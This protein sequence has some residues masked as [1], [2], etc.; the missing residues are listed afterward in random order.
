M[1]ARNWHRHFAT[2]RFPALRESRLLYRELKIFDPE[3]NVSPDSNENN[4]NLDETDQIISNQ[5]LSLA[6]IIENRESILERSKQAQERIQTITNR[7]QGSSSPEIRALMHS[8]QSWHKGIDTKLSLVNKL[9]S[10]Q[11]EWERGRLEPQGYVDALQEFLTMTDAKKTIT[12]PEKYAIDASTWLQLSMEER[13]RIRLELENYFTNQDVGDPGSGAKKLIEEVE[14]QIDESDMEL[15]NLI[16]EI[17]EQQEE[18]SGDNRGLIETL[19]TA[20][21]KIRLYSVMDF[22]RAGQKYVEGVKN[23]WSKRAERVSA[24][25]ASQVG[26]IMKFLPLG[27]EIDA[28][29]SAARES[30]NDEEKEQQKKLMEQNSVPFTQAIQSLRTMQHNPNKFNG[31]LEYLADHGWLY[32]FDPTSRKAFG[33]EI[34]R[35]N[36]WNDASLQEYLIRIWSTDSDSGQESQKKRM[37][38]L[39]GTADSI[40][41]IAEQLEEELDR[42]NYWAVYA[43]LETAMNKGKIG[44]SG[45]WI[46]TIFLNHLRKHPEARKYIPIDIHDQL[47]NLGI[48]HPAW[49]PTFLKVDRK[50]LESWQKSDDPDAFQYSGTLSKAI[51]MIEEEITQKFGNEAAIKQ[52]FGNDM[53]LNRLVARVLSAQVVSHN[54]VSVTLFSSRYSRY[55]EALLEADTTIEV[56]K[57][58]DDFYGNISDAHLIGVGGIRSIFQMTTQGG[59]QHLTKANSY[60]ANIFKLDEKLKESRNMDALR[61]YRKEMQDKLNKYFEEDVSRHSATTQ[62]WL[63]RSLPKYGNLLEQFKSHGMLSQ[64][65]YDTVF[66]EELAKKEKAS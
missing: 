42:Y 47:G 43:A 65:V 3:E 34:P 25:L 45:T 24:G 63:T 29:L 61:N 53:T 6:E 55:R 26:S 49:T 12:L 23:A 31:V 4:S 59:F 54:G 16:N 18:S 39:I 64:K 30:K 38:N 19:Q 32:D 33:I 35:P 51:V 21:G 11:E 20:A 36:G 44:E 40:E 46:T 57:A 28:E 2:K 62:G 22:I 13:T 48:A 37:S 7:I 27:N 9:L 66:G 1:L 52:T 14:A 50:K 15:N 60:I 41:P 5:R 58:D 56:G 8:M 10:K 17:A